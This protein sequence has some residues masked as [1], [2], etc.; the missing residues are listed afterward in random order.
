MINADDCWFPNSLLL[1]TLCIDSHLPAVCVLLYQVFVSAPLSTLDSPTRRHHSLFPL[2]PSL[3]PASLIA[4]TACWKWGRL[5]GNMP[6]YGRRVV[7]VLSLALTSIGHQRETETTISPGWWIITW[8]G[9]LILHVC[10]LFN[11]WFERDS[12]LEACFMFVC[13]GSVRWWELPRNI[14]CTPTPCCTV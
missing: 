13:G 7:G 14:A 2:L 8:E 4:S 1:W 3:V 11:I 10:Y 6:S 9:L 5:H 12:V